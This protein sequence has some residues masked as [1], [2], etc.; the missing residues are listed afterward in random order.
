MCQNFFFLVSFPCLPVEG[1]I[2]LGNVLH[3]WQLE[4]SCQVRLPHSVLRPLSYSV[5]D[6]QI[7]LR[8]NYQGRSGAGD[9]GSP[10]HK[11]AC[12]EHL[13]WIP[14]KGKN[15]PPKKWTSECEKVQIL[16]WV[17]TGSPWVES[18]GFLI[19]QTRQGNCPLTQGGSCQNKHF[20]DNVSQLIFLS[21]SFPLLISHLSHSGISWAACASSNTR[22]HYFSCKTQSHLDEMEQMKNHL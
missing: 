7:A 17:D 15:P 21:R 2:S 12:T 11:W 4:S 9:D 1:G 20:G 14:H 13:C 5:V 6:Q 8:E 19:Q 3:S 16:M 10:H 18:S 22:G